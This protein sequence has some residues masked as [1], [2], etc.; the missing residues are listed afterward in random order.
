M[1]QYDLNVN[2]RTQK[3]KSYRTQLM[4]RGWVPGVIYGKKIDN[5][6]VEFDW[7]SLYNILNKG[8]RNAI[9]NMSVG[10]AGEYKVMVKDM[11]YDAIRRDLIHVDFQHISMDDAI[12]VAV[13]IYISGDVEEGILQ[14]VLRELNVSCLPGNIPDSIIVDVTGMKTGDNIAVST[15][16][17]PEG[18][19]V[20]DDLDSIVATV[21][22]QTVEETE[23]DEEGEEGELGEVAEESAG[24]NKETEG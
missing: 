17:L 22:A 8:G 15:L 3:G 10:D 9:I 21:V 11:Q 5:Q 24:D 23:Q 19:D 16:S 6:L 20:L 12:Q 1:A 18:V 7:R 13:P 2:P 4:S 14:V